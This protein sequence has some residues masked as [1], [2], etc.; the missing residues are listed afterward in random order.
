MVCGLNY[1]L[2]QGNRYI[3]LI[4]ILDQ[5]FNQGHNSAGGHRTLANHTTWLGQFTCP[6]LELRGDFSVHYRLNRVR[7]M[8]RELDL[9]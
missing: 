4:R 8:L 2:S 6:V 1:T 5:A 3:Y 7:T 9:P